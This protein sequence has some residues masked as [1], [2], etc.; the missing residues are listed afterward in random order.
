MLLQ[1]SKV[2]KI[3]NEGGKRMSKEAMIAL[4]AHVHDVLDKAVATHDG[5][6]KTLTADAINFVCGKRK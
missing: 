6:R 5:G 2:K 1:Q 3:V 4:D